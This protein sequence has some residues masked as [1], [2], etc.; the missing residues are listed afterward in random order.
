MRISIY[1]FPKPNGKATVASFFKSFDK[2]YALSEKIIGIDFPFSSCNGKE[3]TGRVRDVKIENGFARLELETELGEGDL[4]SCLL[5]QGWEETS[6][7][8]TE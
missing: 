8:A 2:P 1:V 5:V 6:F 7:P 4:R 3:I